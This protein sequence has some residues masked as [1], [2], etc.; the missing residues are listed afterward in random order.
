MNILEANSFTYILN[1]LRI[2]FLA[3]SLSHIILI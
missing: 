2:K 1:Y 3:E